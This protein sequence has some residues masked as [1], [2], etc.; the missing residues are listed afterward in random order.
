MACHSTTSCSGISGEPHRCMVGTR[1]LPANSCPQHF[2]LKA[3]VIPQNGSY[4]RPLN[5]THLD[6]LPHK[7]LHSPP[8]API[9]LAPR[10]GQIHCNPSTWQCH[11]C[12]YH[13]SE[14]L[15]RPSH[16]LPGTQRCCPH[17]TARSKYPPG[18]PYT[19]C[20]ASC[21]RRFRGRRQ[22]SLSCS[23]RYPLFD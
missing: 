3:V 20:C 22:C 2:A 13:T 5:T 16:R 1:V 4:L 9:S 12:Q 17:H 8:T 19:Q 21:P 14:I 11:Q 23:R 7:A 10:S 6:A 15:Q 18:I